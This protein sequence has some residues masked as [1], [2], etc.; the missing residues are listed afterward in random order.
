[1]LG[2]ESPT[3]GSPTAQVLRLLDAEIDALMG[4]AEPHEADHHRSRAS[5]FTEVLQIL[6]FATPEEIKNVAMLR[7]EARMEEAQG[8]R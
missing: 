7:Y 8:E 6:T 1:M 5:A 3:S 4:G 2:L